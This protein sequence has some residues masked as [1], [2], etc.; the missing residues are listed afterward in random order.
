MEGGH[1]SRVFCICEHTK[2]LHGP[3]GWKSLTLCILETSDGPKHPKRAK[4]CA[5]FRQLNKVLFYSLDFQTQTRSKEI[6]NPRLAEGHARI[7]CNEEVHIMDAVIAAQLVQGVTES[8]EI[9]GCPFPHDSMEHYMKEGK[10]NEKKEFA[11][12]A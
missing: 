11:W 4:N 7:M 10:Q 1:S 8:Q 12:K 6:Y 9:I 3:R 5:T 2:T